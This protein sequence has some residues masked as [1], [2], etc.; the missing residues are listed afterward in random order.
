MAMY[1][2]LALTPAVLVGVSLADAVGDR[3]T[4]NIPGTSDEYPNWRVPLCDCEGKAVLLE[5][6]P[7]IELVQVGGPGCLGVPATLSVR[8]RCWLS[9]LRRLRV[10][11]PAAQGA[12]DIVAALRQQ[13]AQRRRRVGLLE[14]LGGGVDRLGGDD[15]GRVGVLGEVLR[16][17][18]CPSPA[19]CPPT[20]SKNRV[21]YGAEQLLLIG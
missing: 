4:Q 18:R 13:P 10:A 12:R 9:P 5:D 15:R 14:V 16:H 19:R 3:R 7:Q 6:L 17:V 21:A 2:Y 8:P 1:G 11:L 20:T